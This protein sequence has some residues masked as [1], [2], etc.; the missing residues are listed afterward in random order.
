MPPRPRLVPLPPTQG[1][2]SQ[3][4]RTPFRLGSSSGAQLKAWVPGVAEV[5]ATILEREDGYAI[6]PFGPGTRVRVDGEVIDGPTVLR[7]GDI[8]ELAP[9]AR[10]EF[11][12]GAPRPVATA[13]APAAPVYGAEA[14]KRPWWRPR[15]RRHKGSGAGFPLWGWIVGALI[16]AGIAAVTLKVY[17]LV[18]DSTRAPVAPPALN[19]FEGRLYDSLMVEATSHI[20]R[21]ATLLD[22]GARDAGARELAAAITTFDQSVLRDNPWVR[23]GVDVMRKTVED[24]YRASRLTLPAGWRAA[25]RTTLTLSANLSANLVPDQFL[26]AVDQVRDAFRSRY[27]DS[28]V[29]TGR[30]H[31]EHLS[32]YGPRSA[33]DIRVR[34][35]APDQVQFLVAGFQQRG[36]RVKDFS[37]DAVL[38][39][40]V[41]AALRAGVP[42]RA[43]T[44][45]HL[46]VDRFRDRSDR[47][48]VRR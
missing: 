44:G 10:Y 45:V 47:W 28:V 12:T 33:M 1:E 2:A 40:Q 20:E 48:T 42:D 34:G 17:R 9:G 22:L 39:A 30:D 18:G 8:V 27:R 21:G 46:H 3:I 38:R 35:L 43:G 31:P 15:R 37:T 32:L 26:S 25:P 29:V 19:E 5:H 41:A 36:I 14:G 11:V 6:A 23:Q 4:D 16:I 24:L 7:D 13:P